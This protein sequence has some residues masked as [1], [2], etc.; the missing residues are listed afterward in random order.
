MFD[1]LFVHKTKIPRRPVW[2]S[3]W[4]QSWKPM[5]VAWPPHWSWRN[6]AYLCRFSVDR[7]ATGCHS[8]VFWHGN[9]FAYEQLLL[10]KAAR[11]LWAPKCS[12]W[13]QSGA[14]CCEQSRRFCLLHQRSTLEDS[15]RYYAHR[16]KQLLDFM[17]QLGLE[18]PLAAISLD[19]LNP[20]SCS[21]QV[22]YSAACWNLVTVKTP[23]PSGRRLASQY[24]C[25]VL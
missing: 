15:G 21:S 18:L 23:K 13:R 14:R 9:R 7:A 4:R 17:N 19:L 2:L 10:R 8:S 24:D 5:T 22:F 20:L 11:S 12:A 25:Q 6:L 16:L 3:S 1:F